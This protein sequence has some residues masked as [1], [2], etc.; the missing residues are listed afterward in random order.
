[1]ELVLLACCITG[2]IISRPIVRA[3]GI[4]SAVLPVGD[5]SRPGVIFAVAVQ[6]TSG[7]NREIQ[8]IYRSTLRP[9]T[10]GFCL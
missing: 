6:P 2:W 10:N 3:L 9:A 5:R 8:S 1:M 4:R 7:E